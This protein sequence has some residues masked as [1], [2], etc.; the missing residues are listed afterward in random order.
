MHLI[1]AT[2]WFTISLTLC[3][4]FTQYIMSG[5]QT[6]GFITE[7]F[8]DV[9][10][11]KEL[12]CFYEDFL[13]Y[14][15]ISISTRVVDTESQLLHMRIRSP[16]KNISK[17]YEGIDQAEF[18]GMLREGGTYEIC[19]KVD[20]TGTRH[21]RLMLVIYAHHRGTKNKANKLKKE[22][23]ETT[24]KMNESISNLR[25][26]IASSAFALKQLKS[27]R[28]IHLQIKN[29]NNIDM[30]SLIQTIIILCTAIVQVFIIRKFFSNTSK[31][32][33]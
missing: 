30:F 6:Y 32:V 3:S 27:T 4:S 20:V 21:V 14:S 24:E 12:H 33:R 29:A 23:H 31:I 22:H 8:F 2:V 15:D 28:D 25:E 7:L 1:V 19:T 16:S 11:S 9:F 13:L 17:W 10:S 18:S 26:M 5:G